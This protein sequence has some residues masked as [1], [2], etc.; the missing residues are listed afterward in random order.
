MFR[1]LFYTFIFL[2]GFNQL[3]AQ[4]RIL[5]LH[6]AA[7]RVEMSSFVDIL[8]DPQATLEIE[9]VISSEYA[10]TVVPEPGQKSI[11][12]MR[13]LKSQNKRAFVENNM[14][15]PNFGFSNSAYW[16]RIKMRNSKVQS[17]TE[18]QWLIEAG[19]PSLDFIYVYVPDEQG[20][21]TKFE[22]GDKYPF[23]LRQ[24][25]FR[26]PVFRVPHF[27]GEKV[28][29][30]RIQTSGT[31]DLPL[32]LYSYSG[33]TSRAV[34]EQYG[35]GLYFGIMIAMVLYN[36]FIF[37]STR[38][39]GYIHYVGFI[40]CNTLFQ[41][42]LR[43]YAFQY[44]WP[45]NIWWAHQSAGFFLGMFA[46]FGTQ[47]TRHFLNT[48]EIAPILDKIL[49]GLLV[50]EVA[51]AG[52]SLLGFS[53]EFM[54]RA[55]V[56]GGGSFAILA[57]ITGYRCFFKGYRP[58][59]Y[60]NIAFTIYFAA[61]VLQVLVR[62]SVVPFTFFTEQAEQMGFAI[63]VILLS[64]GLADRINIMKREKE[65]AQAE[66][67]E[68]RRVMVQSFSRFVPRQFLTLLGRESIVD[69]GLGDSVEKDFTV[70]FTDIR[71][72]TSLS[73]KMTAEEN[74]RFL[75]SFLKRMGPVIHKNNGFIDKFMGD[76]IMALFPE[77]PQ[78]ALEAAIDMR[79]EL[80]GYNRHRLNEGREEINIGIGLHTGHLMLGT[81]GSEARLDTTVIGDTVNLASRLESL[82]K[83]FR[84]PILVSQAV[85][86]RLPQGHV[87]KLREIDTVRVKGR[88]EPVIIYEAYDGDPLSLQNQ[89]DDALHDYT[90]AL[91][92]YKE[93]HFQEAMA[94]FE[95]LAAQF[96]DD[97]AH[98]M[99]VRRCQKLL[100]EPPGTGWR[101]VSRMVMK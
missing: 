2:A 97:A 1:Y 42:N 95:R 75:N 96:P 10:A 36:L 33:F 16:L 12:V 35:Y 13:K 28:I 74:F 79:R 52:A 49:L 43:G 9:N 71:S 56:I 15:R 82:T 48:R 81:V 67:L 84:I 19:Y 38:D 53:H 54:S 40:F 18:R 85:Y 11:D 32:T 20:G 88:S 30:I 26:N 66:M 24:F 87:F 76:A 27:T 41:M 68:S 72:F 62:S 59:R 89:K 91:Q 55:M 29:Y 8:E 45:D 78:Q 23:N 80:D 6:E 69:V 31:A 4:P 86:G 57:A 65:I 60:F 73:E 21:Y 64:L 17:P 37:V 58:A 77:S 47:F 34:N 3:F 51:I 50:L 63:Q 99:Y 61:G 83:T 44:L 90:H 92:L 94:I 101:G 93:G 100:A 22:G 25:N 5:D 70:L 46:A 98:G 14:R 7:E 39:T